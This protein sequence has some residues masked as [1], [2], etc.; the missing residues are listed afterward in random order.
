MKTSTTAPAA[1]KAG[2]LRRSLLPAAA[3]GLACVVALGGLTAWTSLGNAG[4]PPD[5]AVTRARVFLPTGGT[6]DTAAFFRVI[7][8]GDSADE[9]TEVTSPS[10]GDGIALSRHRMTPDGAAY[11]DAADR[12]QVPARGTLDM[13]PMSSDGTVPAGPAWSLGDRISFDLHFTHSGTVRVRAEV[14]RPRSL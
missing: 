7:N 4:T 2:R 3:P 8:Q 9:L 13:S 6:P 12:L 10:I 1:R 14:V 11:R 5:L